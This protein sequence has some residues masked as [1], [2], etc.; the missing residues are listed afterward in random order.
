MPIATDLSQLIPQCASKFPHQARAGSAGMLKK[1]LSKFAM[2]IL[3]SVAATIIGAYIVNHYIVTKPGANA[4]VSA[5]VS[6]A[7]PAEAKVAPEAAKAETA[8]SEATRTETAKTEVPK[9]EVPKTEAARTG[10]KAPQPSAEIAGIP[11]AGV[12]AKGISEKAILER[13]AVEKPI[14]KPADR[15]AETASIPVETRRHQPMQREKAIARSA[16]APVVQPSAPVSAPVV[17]APNTAAAVEAATAPEERRDANDLARAAIERLRS[18]S[19]GSP[20]VQ[21]TVRVP[22]PPRAVAA[23]VASAPV[24]APPPVRPL[25]PPIMVSTPAN[26][27][28]DSNAG[29]SQVRPSYPA[30]PASSGSEDP[31]RPVPPADIPSS[32]SARPPLDLHADAREP[33]REHTTVAEDMLSAAKSMFHAVLPKK[34]KAESPFSSD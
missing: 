32:P 20:R 5:A 33:P 12:K 29:S 30:Y 10:S 19:D 6:T 9:T 15:P 2:D 22:D 24:V 17:A 14:E 21:E 25:P 8:K 23:P 11:E 4:P 13:S 7:E 1:Y 18:T 26:E 28:F 3:P 16:P 34:D 27:T 31:R